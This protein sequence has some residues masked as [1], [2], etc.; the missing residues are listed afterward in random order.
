[1]DMEDKNIRIMLQ[2]DGTRYDG[3]Q[4]QGNT[5]Q[6]IQGRLEAVLE[7]MAGRPVEV[8]GSGRTD[9]GVHALCQVANF[10]LPASLFRDSK[11][12]A[13]TALR[14][15]DYLNQYLPEDIGVLAAEEA[16]PRFHSRLNAV[17]KTYVYRIETADKKD[18][19][20]RKYRYG[21][22][23]EPDV[24]AMRRAASHLIGTHDFKAFCSLKKMKK[25]TV[26]SIER[27]EIRREGTKL[28]LVFEGNGFLHN[29]VRILVG[30]LVEAGLHERS[31]ESVKEA[32]KSRDRSLAGKTAPALGL[33]LTGVTYEEKIFQSVQ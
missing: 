20:E 22:G 2:Y 11:E 9:A 12:G 16:T 15:K 5:Q 19:F 31:V 33:F 21:L 17:S 28:E 26:R 10:H 1:M 27:I 30:T 4:K 25:S 18:V 8:H 6:T 14:I 32:L 13:F 24:E 3:W 29:M 23:R 7:R